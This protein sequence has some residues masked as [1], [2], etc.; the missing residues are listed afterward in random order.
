MPDIII[1]SENI[2]GCD[3]NIVEEQ[4][5]KLPYFRSAWQ[6]QSDCS[7]YEREMVSLI[8]IHFYARWKNEFGDSN[9]K[10]L[11]HLNRITILWGVKPRTAKN[12]YNIDGK[13]LKE[14]EIIGL[15][16][17]INYIWVLGNQ[18]TPIIETALIHELV[19]YALGATT[20]K[21]DFDHEGTIVPGWTPKHTSFIK[22][23]RS[24]L[25]Q[26]YGF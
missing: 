16:Q 26:I 9:K 10:L 8:L 12:I 15:C 18:N 20:G 1:T 5:V 13:H 3:T 17:G 2:A 19:H 11:Y 7:I 24:D 21:T 14:A 6:K 4:M 25:K 22:D 23:L